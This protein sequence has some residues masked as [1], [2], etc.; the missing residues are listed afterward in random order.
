VDIVAH[1]VI[2]AAVTLALFVGL[3][4][5]RGVSLPGPLDRLRKRGLLG[6]LAVGLIIVASITVWMAL[7]LSVAD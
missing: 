6:S 7:V 2:C 4:E 5:A 1:T 3:C